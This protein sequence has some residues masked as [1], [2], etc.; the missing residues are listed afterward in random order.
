MQHD[1]PFTGSWRRVCGLGVPLALIVLTACSNT[2]SRPDADA[3]PSQSA[4]ST[5]AEVMRAVSDKLE[6]LETL[7]P[8]G[9]AVV[10][11]GTEIQPLTFGQ[12]DTRAGR[13]MRADHRF[14]I[15]SIT[16]T[17]VATLLLQ[18]VEDGDLALD[19]TVD[20][21]L[22]DLLSSGDR[23]TVEH[24]LSHRSGLYN[25]TDYTGLGFTRTWQPQELIDIANRRPLWFEPGTRSLYS[26]TNYIVLGLIAEKVTGRT[27]EHLLQTRIF[28][29]AGMTATSLEWDRVSEPPIAHG[30]D[31]G[32]DVTAADLSLIWTA[33]G[34]V[35][36]APDVTRFMQALFHDRWGADLLTEMSTWRG[37]DYG[38]GLDSSPISCDEAWG[39]GGQI[40]GFT[41]FAAGLP[42]G[43]RSIV[44][45]VNGFLDPTATTDIIDAS[46]CT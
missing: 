39:H 4:V 28:D 36:T 24:L 25:Y 30:Y 22:P 18:L 3:E 27:V 35:S 29:P 38:L 42:D 31:Q 21:H 19:D 20:A 11:L 10:R 12:A 9:V 16:K 43:T 32:N 41:S 33:G 15:G 8:G 45:L 13:A 5:T 17:M 14:Q 23:I 44:I 40:P 7:V 2:A 46:L 6:A 37:Q 34:V 1:S 26:N